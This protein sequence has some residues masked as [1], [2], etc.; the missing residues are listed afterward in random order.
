MKGERGGKGY[1]Q[2]KILATA[3]VPGIANVV[4]RPIAGR[5]HLV[6]LM[7][8]FHSHG[9]LFKVSRLAIAVT[10]ALQQQQTCRGGYRIYELGGGPNPKQL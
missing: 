2:I 8:W 7:A 10:V 1:P 6:N 3:L 9:C 4:P 5:C